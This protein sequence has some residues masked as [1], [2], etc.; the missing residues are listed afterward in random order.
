MMV[1]STDFA[2]VKT[3]SAASAKAAPRGRRAQGRAAEG[4]HAGDQ[5]EAHVGAPDPREHVRHGERGG[6]QQGGGRPHGW[7]QARAHAEQDGTGECAEHHGRIHG[8]RP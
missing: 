7:R 5:G 2:T 8:I 6:R 3:E 4:E 1:P